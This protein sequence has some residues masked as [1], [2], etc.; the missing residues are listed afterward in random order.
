METKDANSWYGW[1][2]ND[3][4]IVQDRNIYDAAKKFG[5]D[6]TAGLVK[7]A[8]PPAE[9]AVQENDIPY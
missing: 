7:V 1:L 4:S 2:I 9:G 3:A 5:Q 6:V 8:E